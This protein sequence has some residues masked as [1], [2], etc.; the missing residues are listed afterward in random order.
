MI[1]IIDFGSQTTHL[2][3]RRLREI[4]VETKIVEPE[5][6]FAETKDLSYD[7]II[8][9]GG[10]TSVYEEGAPTIDKKVFETGKPILGICYGEQIIAHV[11]DGE[12]KP[13]KKKEYGPA[14]LTILKESPLFDFSHPEGGM[15]EGSSQQKRD[16]SHLNDI[17]SFSVWMNHGDELAQIPSGF[18]KIAVTET[19]PYAAIADEER[20]IYGVQFHPEVVHTQFGL[21]I[22]KNFAGICGLSP[23]DQPITEE[24]VNKQIQDIKDS[25]GEAQVIGALSGGVDS[26]I[27]CLM[28]HKAIGDQFTAIY[29]D[30]GLMRAGE[31]EE[32]EK[33]FKE[34]YQMNVKIVSAEEEFLNNLEGVTDPEKKRKII[35]KTF[36]D[37]LEREAKKLDATFLVQGTIYPDVIESAGTKHAKNIKS[38]HNVGGL[39]EHMN[40]MLLEPIRN[41]YK[42]EVR[43]IGKILGL[44]KEITHRHPFP[45]PGLAIRTIGEVSKQKLEILRRADRIVQ[46]EIKKSGTVD[47]FWQ[48]FAIFTGVKTTGVRGDDRAYGET[49]A[50]RAVESKDVMSAGFA[51]LPWELLEAISVRIV[52]EV[53]EVNRVVYDITNKPPGTIE[54]E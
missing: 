25:V 12:V 47:D 1:I 11:L 21:Q 31:T 20:K 22:L 48:V 26:S 10:P 13:G 30:S 43:A 40:I 32:L 42:D 44:P 3:S 34:N 28:V 5:D 37:V 49:I 36:I 54:W 39:P 46:E 29:I 14:T 2:I 51:K 4:S 9:S 53:T 24:F 35:G 38:H 18:E 33:V 17:Q 16:S 8:F 15:T 52:T 23:K 45:G 19:I 7:G 50:I 27:A 6:F 41:F